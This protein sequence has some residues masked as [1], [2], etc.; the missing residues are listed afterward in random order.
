METND[1]TYCVSADENIVAIHQNS[2]WFIRSNNGCYKCELSK[3]CCKI[4]SIKGENEFPFP[5]LS[6]NRIDKRNGLFL[7]NDTIHR[8]SLKFLFIMIIAF[9]L[10]LIVLIFVLTPNFLVK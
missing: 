2:Y 8:R 4:S 3:D 6:D 5:C 9:I 7:S 10:I 1:L